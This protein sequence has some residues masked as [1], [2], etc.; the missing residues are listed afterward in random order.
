[1]TAEPLISIII[2]VLHEQQYI[3]VLLESLRTL[4]DE[5]DEI[6]VVDGSLTQDTNQI[7]TD[8]KVI[9]VASELGRGPQM[10]A[11]AT[12]AHGDILVFLHAD[13]VLPGNALSLIRD[14]LKDESLAGGAF[15]LAVQSK[16]LFLKIIIAYSNL[17]TFITSAPYGDQTIFLR[18]EYFRHLGGYAQIPLMEDVELMRRIRKAKGNIRILPQKAVTSIRRWEQE[19]F[20]YT[21]IRNIIIITLFRCGVP[22]EKLAKLYP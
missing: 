20:L 10:N 21:C 17:R 11:G 3:N 12:A 2:P 4:D 19:G 6:I 8:K 16:N 7:I 15:T 22:A 18:A 14:A 9:K 13:T 5:A 1:M